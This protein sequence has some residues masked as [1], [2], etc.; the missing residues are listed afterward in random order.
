M[1][2]GGI[3]RGSLIGPFFYIN[4]LPKNIF[5]FLVNIY[6]DDTIGYR[7][8]SKNLKEQNLSADLSSNI[9]KEA[10]YV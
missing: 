7:N 9:G 8:T 6:E 5:R 3:P 10:C 2:N 1:I 4:D